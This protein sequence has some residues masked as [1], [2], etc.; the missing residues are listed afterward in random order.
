M[1]II[2][3]ILLQTIWVKTEPELLLE[4][5]ADGLDYSPRGIRSLDT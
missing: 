2:L 4:P 3:S 5:T 1:A